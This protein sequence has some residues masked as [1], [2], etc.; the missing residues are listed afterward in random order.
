MPVDSDQTEFALLPETTYKYTA[1]PFMESAMA[2]WEVPRDATA[3]TNEYGVAMT[4]S[5]T[6]FSNERA[7]AADPLVD[8]GLTEFAASDLVICQSKTAREA[9]ETLAKILDN[10][11]SS[12]VN[13]ALF[14]DQNEAWYMEMYTGH[15]Y[16][17]VKL[18]DDQ[19]SMFGNEFTMEY[20]SDYE[21]CIVSDGLFSLPE[22]NGFAVY[23]KS[24]KNES[25]LNLF[26]TY[27]GNEMTKAYSHMRTWIGH[28]LMAPEA[29]AKDYD[30][31][32]R[33]PLCFTPE[34]QV[35]LK[36]VL[37]MIR[38]RFEG[39]QYSPDETGRIDMRVVGTD[40][41]LSVHAIQVYPDLPAHMSCVTWE[42][43]GP[44]LYGVF[45]PFSNASTAVHEAYGA[46]QPAKETGKFDTEH[47]PYYTFKGLCT[48][49]VAA[50]DV[51]TYGIP[52]RQYW[53]E[54]ESGMIGG[55]KTVLEH[56]AQ[57]ED[58]AMAQE[59]ITEYCVNMQGQA[60]SDAKELYNTVL[61]NKA[62]NS[63]T[64]KVGRNPETGEYLTTER[65]LDP[66][67]I[68]LDASVYQEI[69]EMP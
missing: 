32:E 40:T 51:P 1:T 30:A 46:D 49:C 18:P 13:I 19:V 20:L 59:F 44:A 5:V 23:G 8:T 60:F 58:Q 11:G 27:S 3:C 47:Y 24:E 34:K 67:E 62:K 63:N 53:A 28:Q 45:V 55:M 17:A 69:P 52:V 39:T 68:K 36:D 54:A 57:M 4:M 22:E 50:K 38:N 42:S 64:M 31:M 9:V 16:A 48:E 14:A 41:A 25:E 15:Q 6:A 61:Y 35:S 7:L 33:Y 29:Y 2:K 66:I 21:D 10:F 65:K 37:T 26:D 56:V 12:E 43:T